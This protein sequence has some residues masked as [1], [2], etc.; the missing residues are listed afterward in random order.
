MKTAIIDW[1]TLDII[2]SAAVTSVAVLV[3]DPTIITPFHEQVKNCMKLKFDWK[4]QLANGRTFSQS[5][6]DFWKKPENADAFATEV[7]PNENDVQLS[8]GN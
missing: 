2:P 4:S 1:E 8:H 3:F 5:T 7:A 6:I